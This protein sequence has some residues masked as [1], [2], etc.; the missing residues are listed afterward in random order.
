MTSRVLP[1][2][3]AE[4]SRSL[5][6]CSSARCTSWTP[7]PTGRRAKLTLLENP[8][9]TTSYVPVS[10]SIDRAGG[11]FGL[12]VRPHGLTATFAYDDYPGQSPVFPGPINFALLK[13]ANRQLASAVTIK[14]QFSWFLLDNGD[15]A[16]LVQPDRVPFP[17]LTE[18]MNFSQNVK[19]LPSTESYLRVE[20]IVTRGHQF[21]DA[22]R[23][24]RL[25]TH[26][27]PL[28]AQRLAT[29]RACRGS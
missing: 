15:E 12:R 3:R 28:L 16:F 6:R 21:A 27:I 10:A 13:A 9:D 8:S 26:T 1:V 17:T 20:P 19:G 24:T 7:G 4:A 2:A 23:F 25:S 11:A 18:I 14:N 22:Y 29:V 5:H